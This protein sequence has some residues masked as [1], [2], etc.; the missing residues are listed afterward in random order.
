MVGTRAK[1]VGALALFAA[2]LAAGCGEDGEDSEA[3]E[4]P[5]SSTTATTEPEGDADPEDVA[6]G[7]GDDTGADG[8]R[9]IVLEEDFSDDA[10]GWG[11]EEGPE[12]SVQFRNGYFVMEMKEDIQ[13]FIEYFPNSLVEPAEAGELADVVVEAQL[14]VGS[15]GAAIVTCYGSTDLT[16][17]AGGSGYYF[18][19]TPLE[20]AGIYRMHADREAE[21]L[22]KAE[23]LGFVVD[24]QTPATV[25]A[26]CSPAGDGSL[27]LTMSVN[28][29]VILEA[30]DPNPPEPGL[31]GV[32]AGIDSVAK[33]V[34]GRFEPFTAAFDAFTVSAG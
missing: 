12:V 3:A 19:V 34:L 10:A 27:D 14:H 6:D 16:V 25:T 7:S 13:A 26:E 9:S 5:T 1:R 30:N 28:G 11:T 23:S 4:A 18:F 33:N 8:A 15:P 22:A 2:V 24:E 17:P 29:E 20:R 31:V 21:Q 32:A